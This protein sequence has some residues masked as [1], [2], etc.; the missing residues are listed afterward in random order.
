[1]RRIANSIIKYDVIQTKNIPVMLLSIAAI[2][3]FLCICKVKV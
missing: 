2:S 3:S 1:M